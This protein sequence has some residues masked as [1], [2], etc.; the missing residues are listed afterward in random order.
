[1]SH[2]HH[3]PGQPH[4]P[5][6]VSLSILRLSVVERLAVAAVVI[7]GLWGAAIWAMW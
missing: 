4:Q 3:A 5:A 2:H 7:V 1:M 6:S